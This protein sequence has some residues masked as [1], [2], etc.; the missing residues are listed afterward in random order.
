MYELDEDSFVTLTD[1]EGR[2]FDFLLLDVF[3]FEGQ[4]Y[5]ALLPLEDSETETDEDS[6]IFM[7]A[8]TTD[9]GEMYRGIDD[10]DLLYRLVDFYDRYCQEQMEQAA[11]R[12]AKAANQD[13]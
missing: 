5:M 10:E 9:E 2:E 13:E 6:V 1:E 3:E 11:A 12:K 4:D 7:H 8:E